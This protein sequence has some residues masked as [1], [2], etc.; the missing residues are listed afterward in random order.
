MFSAIFHFGSY[1][2]TITS[3]VINLRSHF[4]VC[5]KKGLILQELY[6][7]HI[8]FLIDKF[9]MLTFVKNKSLINES[10]MCAD[11]IVYKLWNFRVYR[12]AVAHEEFLL[13]CA[14]QSARKQIREFWLSKV[15][16]LLI[17][18][19]EN[20]LMYSP[21]LTYRWTLCRSTGCRRWF[22]RYA[23]SLTANRR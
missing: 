20:W 1:R 19:H 3:A 8:Q 23:V 5:P 13:L 9:N 21:C 10:G 12:S 4:Y 18:A 17:H 22:H 2:R 11:I 7:I 15:G 14:C 16:K 6:Y